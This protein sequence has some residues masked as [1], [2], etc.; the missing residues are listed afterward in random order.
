MLDQNVKNALDL[1]NKYVLHG[2]QS[3]LQ[4]LTRWCF[5]LARATQFKQQL[6]EANSQLEKRRDNLRDLVG[7]ETLAET[8]HISEQQHLDHRAVMEVLAASG[9]ENDAAFA[10]ARLSKQAQLGEAQPAGRSLPRANKRTEQAD[11]REM[12]ISQGGAG[13]SD[14]WVID[15]SHLDYKKEMDDNYILGRVQPLPLRSEPARLA[16]LAPASQGGW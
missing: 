2:E 15:D 14:P 9:A 16:L 5:A 11:S 4:R 6:I 1:V 13:D 8:K 12:S 10:D 7:V 3:G